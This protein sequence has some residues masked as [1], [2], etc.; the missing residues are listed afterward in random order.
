MQPSHQGR[1]GCLSL[2]LTQLDIAVEDLALGK[3]LAIGQEMLYGM[4]MGVAI[5]V[6]L[7]TA[8]HN[9]AFMGVVI[10]IGTAISVAWGSAMEERNKEKDA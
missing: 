1:I 7:G 6:A 4:M 9:V 3:D 10:G 5:G 2:P 8:L